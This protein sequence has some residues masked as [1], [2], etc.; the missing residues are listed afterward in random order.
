MVICLMAFSALTGQGTKLRLTTTVDGISRE[1]FLHIPS[2]YDGKQAVPLVFMLH[3]TG[4]D[5][6][7]MYNISGWAEVAEKE[8]LIAVFPSSMRYKIVDDGEEK[9]TTKWNTLPDAS[10]YLQPG[11]TGQDDIK[12]LR[13]VLREV[14]AAYKIDLN[15]MY[16]NGFS[17]GG[18]MAAK[19]SIEMSDLLAAVCM[20]A[21]S[22]YL[23]TVY[24]P[25]RKI[26]VLYQVGNADY[27]PGNVGPEIPLSYFDTLLSTPNLPYFGGRLYRTARNITRN[28]SLKSEHT[29]VGDTN[30]A[31][32]ATY[33]PI[34]IQDKHELK[35]IFV[36][37]L[38]HSY[39]DWA[40]AEHWKWMRQYT[41]DNSAPTAFTLT[42][43]QGYG[44]GS[45]DEGK[46]LHIW[47]KQIDGKVFTHWSGDISYLESPNEYHSVVNMPGRNISVTAN[48]ADLLPEM[49]L[50]AYTI[51]GA[52]RIK[53]FYAY[54]P[55]D[56]NKIK[57]IVWFFHGTNGNALNMISDPDTR[58]M[59]NLLMVNNYGIVA[60]TSEESEYDIDFNN[61]GFLRWSYGVDSTLVDI[62]NV[63]IIRDTLINRNLFDHNT[64]HAAIGW[65]AGG[66]FTEFIAN[67]LGW[68]AAIN[69]TSPGN[70]ELSKNPLILVPYLASINENDFNPGVG[71]QGNAEA[72]A[73]VQNYLNRGACAILH[74]Q[75]KA[76]L[77]P[78]RFDRSD[79][80]SESL[81]RDI[82]DEIKKNNGLD[83]D[84]YLKGLASQITDVVLMN[85]G[86]FPVILGLSNAQRAAVVKQIEVTNAEHSLKADINYMSL[87]LIEEGC[88]VSTGTQNKEHPQAIK[89][90]PNPVG[91]VLHLEG[92]SGEW[93][94]LNSHG[95][96]LRSGLNSDIDF[97][98][99]HEGLYF[100][101]TNGATFKV[102][103]M[104]P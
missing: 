80:I 39:P 49:E 41:R 69:H 71:Q 6:E 59:I 86:K 27:G 21:G 64:Q 48:Y 45:Y 82:F 47:S 98:G 10:W 88:G 32:I 67:T 91:S 55:S 3:G 26:P 89:I 77:F 1:Y 7:K 5:G 34:D 62:A 19:C 70:E 84:N 100:I 30:N 79:L 73:N 63:R 44:G 15:R 103:K 8:N 24:I 99:L 46:V 25:S 22:F 29:I 42:T 57:G 37:G 2:S 85:P 38:A 12:F 93:N 61:D 102:L 74:E 92:N 52:Q 31:M 20:N 90:W 17:N 60:L 50:N 16:L 43:N 104:N 14:T 23:D 66:A 9:T 95:N 33:L 83:A 18:Q 76:P 78:E 56:K 51:Q 72:R 75:L 65:S 81:S 68:K 96:R 87:K 4:G 94:L 54:V 13:K 36:K 11:Q 53:K 28:F 101:R 40:A 58:Q 97:S 35:F